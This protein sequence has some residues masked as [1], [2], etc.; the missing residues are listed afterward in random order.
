M[1][2]A[3]SGGGSVEGGSALLPAR[4]YTCEEVSKMLGVGTDWVRRKTQGRQVEH[5][6]LGRNVR[7]TEE[8]V[9]ALISKFTAKSVPTSSAR[10]RL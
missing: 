2:A 9:H 5:V 1:A 7:F 4:L 3:L 6:R 10:T 8:Q